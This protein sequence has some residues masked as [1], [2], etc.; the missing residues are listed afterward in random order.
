MA[1]LFKIVLDAGHGG[2]TL[3]EGSSPNNAVAANGLLEK[4]LTLKIARLVKEKLPS[5]QFQTF[6]TRDKDENLSLK[7][8]AGKS[9][10]VGADAFISIHFNAGRKTNF[11]GTEVFISESSDEKD[12]LL[13]DQLLKNV[14][15]AASTGKRGIREVDFTVLKGKY[16]VAKTAACL[17]EMAYL[18]NPNQAKNLGSPAYLDK[19]ASAVTQSVVNYARQVSYAQSFAEEIRV[20]KVIAEFTKEHSDPKNFPIDLPEFG[21]G[22]DI[23]P[24]EIPNGLKLSRWEVEVLESSTGARYKVVKFPS[25]KSEGKQEIHIEW[26]HLPYGKIHY[27]LKV[28]ASPDGSGTPE[29]IYFDSSGWMEKSKDRI[30]QG[31]P[32]ELAVKGEK[33]KKIYEA[34]RKK[35]SEN[36]RQSSYED[37]STAMFAPAII[38]AGIIAAVIA[39]G[40]LTLGAIIKMA[41]DKG[42][43]V[44][45]TKYKAG[46][47]EGQS[48][49][50]HEIAFNI[51]RPEN[52]KAQSFGL[53]HEFDSGHFESLNSHS[54]GGTPK[55][56][57]KES[58]GS[59]GAN[60][61]PDVLAVKKRLIE[62]GFNWLKAD[63]AVDS[64]TIKTIRLF[65]S[66]IQGS[67]SITGDGK[68]SVNKN[69]HHWLQAKN[70]P[71]WQTM[72]AGSSAEGYVNYELTDTKDTHD[73]GTN[74][75]DQTIKSVAIHYRD[76]YLKSNPNAALLTVNDVSPEQGGNTKD[77]SG[78]E[79]GLACDLQLPRTDGKAGFVTYKDKI[80]DQNAARGVLQALNAQPNVSAIY[81]NDAKLA[82]EGLC[83]T[84]GSW[85]S[86]K[87]TKWLCHDNHIHFEIKPP[88]I[89]EIETIESQGQ[90]L[91]AYG[92]D[93]ESTPLPADCKGLTGKRLFLDYAGQKSNGRQIKFGL[94]WNNQP[95]EGEAID[96]VVHF[97]GHNINGRIKSEDEFSKYV[98]NTSKIEIEKDFFRY[99]ADISGLDLS[100]R[101]SSTIG[102]IPFG[103]GYL[104]LPNPDIGKKNYSIGY[105]FGY[106]TGKAG[107]LEK[108]IDF[109]LSQFAK[110]HGLKK[111]NKN[112]LILTAH[113][114]GGSAVSMILPVAGNKV[115]EVHLFDA[116]YVTQYEAMAEWAKNKIASGGGALRA[117]YNGT[118]KSEKIAENWGN[119]P[120]V[121]S[122][123]Y[124]IEKTAC[125][126]SDIPKKFG[127]LLLEKS[128]A[129][130]NV[131]QCDPPPKPKTTTT[132][133]QSSAFYDENETDYFA[134]REAIFR[135][136]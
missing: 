22:T 136:I 108:L 58:V 68:I 14:A 103:S 90:S 30:L 69:T 52:A 116:I 81:F 51:T 19:L 9:R 23:F 107:G 96:V 10:E 135:N 27:K 2:K 43:D 101:K 49:Q 133:Q 21:G 5:N 77:H 115:D 82:G 110:C 31:I 84:E 72:S 34:L 8:R 88:T 119:V 70:A 66:I 126:H 64:T 36:A 11:D 71:R 117:I 28:Y 118:Q 7:Q 127:A 124:K 87:T 54:L 97:H 25:P 76:N 42:Y 56:D 41:L 61:E 114:G 62:L 59:G 109:A 125:G 60:K 74:W 129:A 78:H 55:F 91:F 102:I 98:D 63:S 65:Q 6:L 95:K 16:H 92:A 18:T 50:E 131:S 79:A 73:Y 113:S 112:R 106:V 40:F 33:A 38:I 12:Y 39:L 134:G 3:V 89:G 45:D 94:V 132:K 86:N 24:V 47:G 111:L 48:R 83:R 80:Y 93:A 75:L 15:N 32:F 57:I 29:K 122:G 17:V 85:C 37:Y 105:N 128:D 13:A 120:A 123:Y 44:K 99:A 130:L 53:D 121:L 26:N 67:N 1:K 100:R 46:A 104:S 35:Q 4:D 20:E